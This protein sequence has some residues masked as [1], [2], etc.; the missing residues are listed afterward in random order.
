MPFTQS[1]LAHLSFSL[2][3]SVSLYV[4]QLSICLFISI[5]P[6]ISVYRSSHLSIHSS[7]SVYLSSIYAIIDA[8]F[9][10]NDWRQYISSPQLCP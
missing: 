3:L 4:S 2:C 9:F 6:P 8:C 10:L 1:H 5:C 7:I